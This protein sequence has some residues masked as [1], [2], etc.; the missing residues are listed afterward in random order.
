MAITELR[1]DGV[2]GRLRGETCPACGDGTLVVET[3]KDNRAVVCEACETP[4]AQLW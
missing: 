2:L 4:R 1:E 3:Y